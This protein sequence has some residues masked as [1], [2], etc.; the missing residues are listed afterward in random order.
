M[1]RQSVSCEVPVRRFCLSARSCGLNVSVVASVVEIKDTAWRVQSWVQ[2]WKRSGE[3]TGSVEAFWRSL[4]VVLQY[5]CWLPMQR[6]WLC[7]HMMW[8]LK[9]S[10]EIGFDI[11]HVYFTAKQVMSLAVFVTRR[12]LS[13]IYLVNK[14]VLTSLD[15]CRSFF[16]LTLQM[17]VLCWFLY[18]LSI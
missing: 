16:L 11:H 3:Q 17:H 18:F 8:L 6:T 1:S 14:L 9:Q 15:C 4:W 2:G 12:V 10:Y 5:S 7:L 13:L